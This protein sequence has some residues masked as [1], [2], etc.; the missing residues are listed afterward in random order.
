M[1]S[2]F[3]YLFTPGRAIIRPINMRK[4]RNIFLLL[5][6]FTVLSV[7]FVAAYMD[8]RQDRINEHNERV[9]FEMSLKATPTP[10]PLV[11]APSHPKTSTKT[12]LIDCT[13]PDKVVFKTTA[14]ECQNF[15]DAW[16]PQPTSQPPQ[17][18]EQQVT[19]PNYNYNY[20]VPEYESTSFTITP[21]PPMPT[22]TSTYKPQ[23]IT[24][25]P[26]PTIGPSTPIQQPECFQVGNSTTIICK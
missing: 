15:N 24:S 4:I 16:K 17:Q 20:Y 26:F 11:T 5:V 10:E 6:V 9:A 18:A 3:L 23:P 13:G 1:F 7:G 8:S 22:Y 14:T 2:Y 21:P 12:A 25:Q 19:Q